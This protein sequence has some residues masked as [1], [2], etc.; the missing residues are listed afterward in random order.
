MTLFPGGRVAQSRFRLVLDGAIVA[1]SLFA[2]SWVSVLDSV[3]R[4]AATSHFALTV[5]LAYPLADLVLVTMTVL[6]LA[7]ARTAQRLTLGLLTAGITLM[8]FSDSAFAYLTATDPYHTG[9]LIDMGWVT[10][11]LLFGL[12]AASSTQEPVAPRHAG[13]PA[14]TPLWLPYMPLLLATGVGAHR[15]LP[16][17]RSGPIPAVSLLL[18]IMVLVRQFT[19]VADN[20]RLLVT[21]AHQAFHDP[22]TG[23]ANRALFTD[24][25]ERAVQLQRREL[26]PLAVLCLDLDDFKPVND[27]FGHAVGD[28]LLVRVAERLIGCLRATDTIARLGGDEFAVLIEQDTD[29]ALL[30][31]H[32]VVDAFT[33]PFVIDGH[34][35]R[36]RPSIGLATAPGDASDVSAESLL[37]HADLAMYAAK[38]SGAGGLHTFLPD[39]EQADPD[40]LT[41]RRT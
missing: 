2:V 3:Y 37:K 34:S 20:R 15:A 38:R 19:T 18:V 16:S 27:T 29:T 22:L 21:V 10:A 9:N 4:A 23:L 25:L 17:L 11:F 1:G 39:V 33:P 40:Q 36:I 5:A 24:R 41:S 8:S 32:R 14:T 28:D 12:A 31:A 26:R 13:T 35:L 7:R 30:A 6:V